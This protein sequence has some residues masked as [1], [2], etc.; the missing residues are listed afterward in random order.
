MDMM[1]KIKRVKGNKEK[2]W[3]DTVLVAKNITCVSDFSLR[4]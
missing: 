2:A 4:L 3:A 1:E